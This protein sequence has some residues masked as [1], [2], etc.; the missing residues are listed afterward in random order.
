MT[1]LRLALRAL[2]ATQVVSL[3][4]ALSLALGIGANTAIF[5]LVN[6]LL[7]RA[8]PVK[9]PARLALMTD[10]TGR[11]INS[12]TNPIWEQIRD[13]RDL[14][15]ASFAWSTTRFNLAAGGETQFV[16]GIWASGLVIAQV[17]LSLI[18][19]VAAGLF[20]RTFSSLANLHLG[21]DRDRVLLVNINAPRTEIPPADRLS[22]YYRIRDAVAAVPGVASAAASFVTPVSGNT[23]NNRVDVSGGVELPERQRVSNFNAITPGWLATFGTPLVAGRD[24]GDGDRKGSTP[25]ILVNQAF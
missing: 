1:D 24:I 6:S 3:L 13:R 18:L 15:D 5:S 12:W 4:A 11:G 19:V 16:D 9:E 22:T 21:F 14:Y 2:R 8:L 17:A 20:M 25:V 7:L 23:W 10:D